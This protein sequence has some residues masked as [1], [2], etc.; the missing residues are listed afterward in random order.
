MHLSKTAD[1][2]ENY[3]LS[4]EEQ[5]SLRYIFSAIEFSLG[6]LLQASEY[7]EKYQQGWRRHMFKMQ[8]HRHQISPGAVS[9]RPPNFR[10]SSRNMRMAADP[11]I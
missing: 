6:R 11:E 5:G 9:E 3:S 8:M 1:Q 7:L 10:N 4:Q 2:I